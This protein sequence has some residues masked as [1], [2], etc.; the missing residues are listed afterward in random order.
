MESRG[1]IFAPFRFAKL[2]AGFVVGRGRRR[3]AAV[4]YVG[5][6]RRQRREENRPGTC[7]GLREVEA[8]LFAPPRFQRASI[9]VPVPASAS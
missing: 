4:L 1:C 3:V 6:W 8:G 9:E 7:P 2:G 5:V